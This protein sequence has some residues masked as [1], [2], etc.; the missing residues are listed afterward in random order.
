M[1][2][3]F[4]GGENHHFFYLPQVTDKLYHMMLYQIQV[5]LAWA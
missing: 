5:L 4:F 3:S 2:V 1:A